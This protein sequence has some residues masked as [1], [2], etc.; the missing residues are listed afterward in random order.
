MHANYM[1]AIEVIHKKPSIIIISVLGS[2]MLP[3]MVGLIKIISKQ[4]SENPLNSL[5]FVLITLSIAPIIEE[6]LFRKALLKYCREN[7]LKHFLLYS[8]II[9]TLV[10]GYDFSLGSLFLL[11]ARIIFTLCFLSIPYLLT[12]R[13]TV[14]IIAHITWNISVIVNYYLIKLLFDL[15]TVIKIA[16][17]TTMSMVLSVIIICMAKKYSEHFKESSVIS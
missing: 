4:S 17:I 10:H 11:L 2:F 12:S 1:D 14:S 6:L 16:S 8:T 9:F 13:L 7:N 5:G 3:Q 15:P